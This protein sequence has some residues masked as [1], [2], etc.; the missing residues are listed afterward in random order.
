MNKDNIP[1]LIDIENHHS[2]DADLNVLSFAKNLPFSAKRIFYVENKS[3]NEIRG[4]HAH[5]ECWQFLIPIYGDFLI[6]C[7]NG[8]KEY[9]FLLNDKNVGLLIPPFIWARQKYLEENN[10]LLVVTSE[11]YDPDDYI[12]DFD[13]FKDYFWGFEIWKL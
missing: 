9:E 5:K 1:K 12:H 11:E 10:I 6:Y 3:K 4:D 13:N 8:S 7:N 2:D